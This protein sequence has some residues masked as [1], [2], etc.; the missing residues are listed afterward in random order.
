MRTQTIGAGTFVLA[1]LA[2]YEAGRARGKLEGACVMGSAMLR[3]WRQ[4]ETMRRGPKS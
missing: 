4:A 3:G 2:A 1:V